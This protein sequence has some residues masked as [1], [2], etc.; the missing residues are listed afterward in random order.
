MK[1]YK[2]IVAFAAASAMMLTLAP[3]A[4]KSQP[5]TIQAEVEAS[6]SVAAVEVPSVV[7]AAV[8]VVNKETFQFLFSCLFV[9]IKVSGDMYVNNLIK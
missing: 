8:S 5:K 7:A 6:M 3:A 2:K 4:E 1:I 9:I